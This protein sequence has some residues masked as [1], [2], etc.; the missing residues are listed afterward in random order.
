M[1]H[2]SR[3]LLAPALGL[4]LVALVVI[5]VVIWRGATQRDA[6]IAPTATPIAPA[7]PTATPPPPT[8][9]LIPATPTRESTPTPT[10]AATATPAPTATQT[11]AADESAYGASLIAVSRA[12]LAARPDTPRFRIEATLDPDQRTIEGSQTLW[13]TNTHDSSLDAIYLRLFANAPYFDDGSTTVSDIQVDGAAAD[14]MLETADTVLRVSLPQPL[15]PGAATEIGLRF[16][17]VVPG[18][19]AGYGIFGVN[20]GTF[21]L[22]HWHPELAAFEDGGWLL[23]PPVAQGDASNT[24]VANYEV[25]FV[26]PEA[27]VVVASGVQVDESTVDD[28]LA[29]SFVAGLARNFVIVAGNQFAWES[30]QVGDT[31]VRSYYRPGSA[32]GGRAALEAAAASLELFNERFGLYP[33]ADLDVVEVA[34]GGGAAGME[35]TGLIMIGSDYYPPEAANPLEALRGLV[36]GIAG[37]DV[38]AFTTAHEVAHQWWFSVVGS[39]PYRAPWLD[40]SITNWSSAFYVDEIMGAEAGAVAR[41]LFMRLPYLDVLARGDQP[42]NKPVDEYGPQQYGAIVYGKGALMY[43]VLREELGDE[44]FWAFLRRYYE[45][46]RWGRAT[47]DSWLRTLNEVAGRDMTPFYEQWVTDATVTEDDL[48]PGGPLS[49]IL[50][51]GLDGALPLPE[52]AP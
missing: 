28:G 8:P 48:P 36:P 17:T 42:L 15:A 24:D 20:E 30:R 23:N 41:D 39:D 47:A 40:E 50:Q 1:S 2:R 18:P 46:H 35:A 16:A 37:A 22:Y 38:L 32:A 52:P 43:D 7:A 9:T 27:Y 29:Y 44:T 19:G 5:A 11:P 26:A 3:R 21:A 13:Y 34:L 49:E 45:D 33:F 4:L 10:T 31:T 14:T 12:E 25:R 6:A 51:A